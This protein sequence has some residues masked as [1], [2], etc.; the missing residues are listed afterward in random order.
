MASTTG[1]GGSERHLESFTTAI[2][3][4]FMVATVENTDVLIEWQ[5]KAIALFERKDYSRW[6]RTGMTGDN[7]VSYEVRRMGVE[8]GPL[9]FGSITFMII[10]VVTTSFR[11][12]PLLSKPWEALVGCFI[13]LLA[14]LGALGVMSVLEMRFQ[15]IMVASL[16]LIIAVGVDDIF[17]L[18]RAWH[19]TSPLVS[20][21]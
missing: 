21:G 13:P 9:L 20:E 7:L 11:V 18:L 12:N 3:P 4:F 14:I 5:K 16:F 6:F 15:S 1:V 8:T 17:M 19:R 2:M 10:F